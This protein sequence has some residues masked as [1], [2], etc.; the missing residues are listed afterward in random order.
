[1]NNTGN[2]SEISPVVRPPRD[3]PVASPFETNMMIR[4]MMLNMG[5]VFMVSPQELVQ[6]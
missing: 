5:K 3:K 1:V 4:V 6:I 2:A